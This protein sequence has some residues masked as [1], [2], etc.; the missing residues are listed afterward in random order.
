[1]NIEQT[2]EM[3]FEDHAKM[4]KVLSSPVRL[5]LFNFISFS[6]RT[7]EDCAQK[8]NQSIQN[9]S[10]HLMNLKNAGILEVEQIKNFR[11]Y[12][13]R[14][15]DLTKQI[16]QILLT[17]PQRLT[18]REWEVHPDFKQIAFATQKGKVTLLDLRDFSERSFLPVPHSLHFDGNL[19]NIDQ[20]IDEK[21]LND[22]EIIIFCK[23]AMCERLALFANYLVPHYK[24]KTLSLSSFELKE[25]VTH[26]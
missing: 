26:F 5:K 25:L 24:V 17:A 4:F 20:F 11:F 2:R 6:P 10:L 22:K 23:G 16:S 13:L 18:P 15:S 21:S 14:E 9:I 1:M 19:K 8:F 3:F 7:V 12:S